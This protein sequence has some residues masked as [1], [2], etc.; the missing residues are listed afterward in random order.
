MRKLCHHGESVD[1]ARVLPECRATRVRRSGPY[2]PTLNVK[3][4]KRAVIKASLRR[5]RFNSAVDC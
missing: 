1:A 4:V 5:G 2:E 3:H